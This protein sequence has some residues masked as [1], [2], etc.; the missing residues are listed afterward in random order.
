MEFRTIAS[1]FLKISGI[2]HSKLYLRERLESHVSYPSLNSLTDILD[3]FNIENSVLQIEKKENWRKLKFPFL[4][5]CFDGKSGHEFEIIANPT[6]VEERSFLSRWSGIA[7]MLGK[8]KNINHAE[9]NSYLKIERIRKY[10]MVAFLLSS[11][12]IFATIHLFTFDLITFIFFALSLAGLVLSGASISY[13]MGISTVL[14]ETFCKVEE[15]EC[16]AVLNSKLA[17]F[18]GEIGLADLAA[19]Y[20]SSLII[21]Q[22]ITLLTQLTIS[23]PILLVLNSLALLVSIISII[24]QAYWK[25][26]CKLC[27]AISAVIWIQ[28]LT[29]LFSQPDNDMTGLNFTNIAL[30]TFVILA[31]SFVESSSWLIIKPLMTSFV[32]SKDIRIRLRKWRQNPMWFNAM[33]P[34]EKRIDDRPWEYEIKYGN[35][36]GVLQFMVI[37]NPYCP[38]CAIAHHELDLIFGKHPSDIGVTMRFSL[39]SFDPSAKNQ[40]AVFNILN[41]YDK[42]VWS[43][44]RGQSSELMK[45]LIDYWFIK[46]DL[47]AFQSRFPMGIPD[48]EKIN[49]L[50]TKSIE[51]C[52]AVNIHQTPAFFINGFEMP[53]PHTFR[54]V[55][56]FVSDYIEIIKLNNVQKP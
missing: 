16:N 6:K 9:H 15:G 10:V 43:D 29:L 17:R 40:I 2:D 53:E 11:A 44:Q 20:F 26:W 36:N 13:T 28:M 14:T 22:L 38:S 30:P 41:A 48:T 50:I 54:D 45:E 25:T 8:Q 12:S 52:S 51:W 24:Y 7:L 1:D 34:L 18:G 19:V 33:L 4:A 55:F 37:N 3:E 49:S 31:L 46:Q 27:L 32:H 5:H 35:P 47:N 42:L 39:R 23:Y 56:H 21:F